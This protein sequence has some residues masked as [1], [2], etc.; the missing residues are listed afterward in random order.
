MVVNTNIFRHLIF[1]EVDSA[2]YGI[3]INGDAV[4][5]SPERQVEMI[6]V[7][8]R[9]GLVALDMGRFENIEI[10]YPCGTF[11]TTQE[12]FAEQLSAFRNA[13]MSLRGYQRLEDTYHPEEFRKAVFMSAIEVEPVSYNRA[14]EFELT[15]NC[16]PQRWLS[17]GDLPI[18]V[19]S[20]DVLENPSPF[21]SS[22]LLEIEGHGDV[23]FN[24]YTVTVGDLYLGNVQ[25]LGQASTN[26]EYENP[27]GVPYALNN[28]LFNVG[29]TV[30]VKPVTFRFDLAYLGSII[31]NVTVTKAGGDVTP[32]VSTSYGRGVITVTVKFPTVTYSAPAQGSMSSA[33][34]YIGTVAVS[35][36]GGGSATVRLLAQVIGNGQGATSPSTIVFLKNVEE[37]AAGP[38]PLDWWVQ[39]IE[40]GVFV[41]STVSIMGHP[42][43]IDCELGEAYKIEDGEMISLNKAIVFGSDLPTLAPGSNPIT[44]DN[45]IT[46]LKIT[47]RWWRV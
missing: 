6:T 44:F 35:F 10:V 40:T 2:D 7:P 36:D 25:L 18:P 3:Y 21:A 34:S 5:N 30:T 29:D 15:F 38:E 11:A 27:Y 12:E 14:G 4:Y 19:D 22:P 13:I 31:S 17:V 39:I 1:G 24:G 45:T 43:Y 33:H 8:G 47:P 37:T 41:D 42:T 9:D 26:Q 16:K 23:N 46:D 32:T 20:G 28:G